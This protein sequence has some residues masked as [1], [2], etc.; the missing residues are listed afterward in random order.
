M[1][2]AQ[3]SI[4]HY[5]DGSAFGGVE[6]TLL[7]LLA[8]TDRSRWRPVLFHHAGP[9]VELLVTGAHEL[10]VTT[11]AVPRMQGVR[12][13]RRLPHFV[14]S[15]RREQ[16]AVF[17]AHL[18]WLLSCKFG[19]MAARIAG[20]PLVIASLQQ[21]LLPPW[22]PNVYWQQRIVASAVDRYVA[23]SQA[24][25]NQLSGSFDVPTGKIGVIHNGI[26]VD[27]FDGRSVPRG[28][29]AVP[30]GA[31]R[32][33]VL[34]VARLDDQKG[35]DFLLE[36]IADIPD[37]TFVF[38]GDGDR[39][40]A[41][42]EKAHRLGVASRVL[43]LGHRTDVPTLLAECDLFVLPSLY[44]GFPLSVLEAMAS[45]KPVVATAVGGTPEAVV[46]GVTGH[47]VRP[48]EPAALADAITRILADPL[49]A[50]GMGLAGR[51]RVREL[52]S[53]AAMTGAYDRTYETVGR[54]MRR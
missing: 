3:R 45:A 47:L 21:F 12:A 35:H 28:K 19:L 13:L 30:D 53:S 34:T 1:R 16:P 32:P 29:S 46:D 9:G 2:P 39:R 18:N 7:Q 42:E 17:H 26:P 20:V 33:I 24:I 25:A 11:R 44:E 37:G 49:R 5:A 22:R 38:A 14:R 31:H 52:F 8:H 48:E 6:R 15:L 27:T 4:V 50:H 43:F 36:A 41:L 51:A 10:G 23:V 54:R 40:A